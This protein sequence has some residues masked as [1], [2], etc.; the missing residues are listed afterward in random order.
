MT[1]ITLCFITSYVTGTQKDKSMAQNAPLLYYYTV[2]MMFLMS[3]SVKQRP[4]HKVKN[5]GMSL[6][7]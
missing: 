1:L 7:L 6:V 5:N 2:E 4:E 3:F